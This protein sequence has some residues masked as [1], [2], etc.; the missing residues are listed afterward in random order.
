MAKA[1]YL[2]VEKILQSTLMPNEELVSLYQSR[3]S[4]SVY[5]CVLTDEIFYKVIRVGDHRAITPY[6]SQP[7]FDVFKSDAELKSEIRE[8]L[9]KNCWYKFDY[10]D[11]FALKAIQE[12][13]TV[14]CHFF[15]ADD[16]KIT[17]KKANFYLLKDNVAKIDAV[18]L[19]PDFNKV[20]RKLFSGG[21]ISIYRESEFDK[22]LYV[23]SFAIQLLK[24]LAELFELEWQSDCKNINWY[25]FDLP[26]RYLPK[27]DKDGAEIERV[28]L[29]YRQ[30]AFQSDIDYPLYPDP[31][32]Y[33]KAKQPQ[34]GLK[35]LFYSF[36]KWLRSLFSK[37]KK[38]QV[39]APYQ[40]VEQKAGGVTKEKT[41]QKWSAKEKPDFKPQR[42][43]VKISGVVNE[44][45]L[46]ALMSLKDELPKG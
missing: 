6:F 30:S 8:F 40:E 3:K 10:K 39:V 28:R 25:H 31:S 2:R 5:A 17:R 4:K 13:A 24:R 27:H 45:T 26:Q 21:L 38:T 7:T 22:S 29:F 18:Q 46:S 32:F 16:Y 36:S 43:N 44:D 34:S 33:Q 9:F 42:S 41:A 37:M 23:S 35:K 12:S 11:Y 19:S 14:N 20:L 1:N 15:L